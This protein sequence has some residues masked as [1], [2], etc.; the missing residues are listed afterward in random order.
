MLVNGR[1]SG[2]NVFRI[3][4]QCGKEARSE[5]S[6]SD[7]DNNSQV[8]VKIVNLSEINVTNMR[9]EKLPGDRKSS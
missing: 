4:F 8:S 2:Q 6:M 5:Q 1:E 7:N 3:F 9:I